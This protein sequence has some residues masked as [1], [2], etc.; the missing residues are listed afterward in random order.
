[1]KNKDPNSKVR[2]DIKKFGW[3]CLNVWP[4]AGDNEHTAFSYTIGLTESYSHPEIM[5]FGLGD[6]AHGVLTECANLIKKGTRFVEGE[7]NGDILSGDFKVIF[8]PV[9]KDR[10]SEYLGT[11]LRYYGGHAFDA[12]VLFWPNK[13]HQFPWESAE[14]GV[15]AE[16]LHVV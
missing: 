5:I 1:M 14:P 11:A 9:R 2:T 10:F 15:Q 6:K 7:P 12:F 8:K 13:Q 3:H 16:A 4:R